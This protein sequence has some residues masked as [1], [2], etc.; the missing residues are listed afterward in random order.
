MVKTAK[1]PPEK[2]N[3]VTHTTAPLMVNLLSGQHSENVQLVAVVVSRPENENAP[4]PNHNMEA[5]L[6]M[7]PPLKLPSVVSYTVP[8]MVDTRNSV[9]GR[10]VQRVAEVERK[11]VLEPAQILNLN[12]MVLNATFLD[13]QLSEENAK[14]NHAPD[15]PSSDSGLNVL[16]AVEV[17]SRREREN[18]SHLDG[19]ESSTALISDLP[20]KQENAKHN[21]VPS[22]ETGVHGPLGPLVPNL[23]VKERRRRPE[24]AT[25][26]LHNSVA[27]DVMDIIPSRLLVV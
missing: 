17:V 22:T 13:H 21:R 3:N 1:E 14:L 11:S 12:T 26:L 6:A 20:K 16:R 15:T 5:N 24:S 10:N 2:E 25:T 18:A 4:T 19:L 7:E 9:P 23:A 27:E 8:S